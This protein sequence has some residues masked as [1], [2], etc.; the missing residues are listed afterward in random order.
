MNLRI[1]R[2]LYLGRS[3]P[4]LKRVGG[5]RY[6]LSLDLGGRCKDMFV[7][8]FQ[9]LLNCSFTIWP[10]SPGFILQQKLIKKH[11]CEIQFSKLSYS[12]T[13]KRPTK[14]IRKHFDSSFLRLGS[15]LNFYF[16][17]SIFQHFPNYHSGHK[18]TTFINRKCYT[19][20][21]YSWY[22]IVRSCIVY[23]HLVSV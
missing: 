9:S 19:N 15:M 17:L 16:L 21:K 8:A 7:L 6:A 5:A 4:W 22:C 18:Y 11:F 12:Y 1:R 13:L 23:T 20:Y 10:L 2:R 3:C 14:Q